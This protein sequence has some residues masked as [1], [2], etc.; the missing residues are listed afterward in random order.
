[1]TKTPPHWKVGKQEARG[2]IRKRTLEGLPVIDATHG[3][4]LKIK[5]PDIT[6]SSKADPTNCAAARALKR[7][8]GADARVY[9]TRT[10][11]KVGRVWMR[12]M[13]P[14]SISREITAFDRGAA[15][16]PGE[17]VLTPPSVTQRLGAVKP[18]GPKKTRNGRS[19]RPRHVT[20]SVRKMK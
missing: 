4:R 7:E 17:Y 13:T 3:L 11:V 16:E 6:G 19:T 1:M 2:Q 15:F 10:Y 18:T 9:L 14:E 5:K 8:A 12:F 20:A